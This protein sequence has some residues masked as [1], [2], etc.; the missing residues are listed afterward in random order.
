[1]EWSVTLKELLRRWPVLLGRG[2]NQPQFARLLLVSKEA[3]SESEVHISVEQR[4][5]IKFLVK[6][7]VNPIEILQRLQAYFEDNTLLKTHVF[8]W[9][10]EFSGGR[11]KV[12]NETHPHRQRTSVTDA[13]IE[14]VRNLMEKNQR[15]TLWEIVE[16]LNISYE[17]VHRIV[18]D[19]LKTRKVCAR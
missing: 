14:A 6:E 19:D 7:G 9:L 13:N 15:I 11:E 12:E 2:D 8:A 17:S 1:M 16:E 18:T 10:K 5:I 3:M 4:I